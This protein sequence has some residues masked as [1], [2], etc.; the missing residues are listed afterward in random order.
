MDFAVGGPD[1]GA[2]DVEAVGE[3]AFGVGVEVVE[4]EAGAAVALGEVDELGGV[5]RPL[6]VGLGGRRCG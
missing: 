2:V 5:G 1:G 6:R 4:V 3:G